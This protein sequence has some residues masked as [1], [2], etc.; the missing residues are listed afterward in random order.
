MENVQKTYLCQVS[1]ELS[2][3]AC[4]GL[5]NVPNLSR[6]GLF[7]LL[8]ERTEKFATVPRTEKDIDEFGLMEKNR[9]NDR[10]R[11]CPEFH[12]C[13]FLGLVGEGRSRV[14]C[15]LH[16]LGSGN[17]GVDHR[18]LSWY[19][20]FACQTYFCPTHR[21]LYDEYKKIVQAV[22]PDWYLYGLVITEKEMLENFFSAASARLGKPL[23]ADFIAESPKRVEAV[24]EF[25]RLKESWPFRP[26]DSPRICHYFFR[27][28]L[29]PDTPIPYG[30]MGA[31]RSCLDPVL[32]ALGS[33][34]SSALELDRA[35]EMIYGILEAVIS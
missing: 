12:H 14:G 34:I 30:E 24:L 16:P 33:R 17:H 21:D 3:G 1:E 18:G 5:Y 23:T 4:C 22:R 27:D 13:P 29:Y 15:L 10:L 26:K 25:L 9:V 6:E 2:C 31:D 32:R 7:G 20:A 11:P 28:G 8:S 35:E 19:G